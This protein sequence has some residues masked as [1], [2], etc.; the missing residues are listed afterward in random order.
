MEKT[1]FL[2]KR[3]D[4][5]DRAEFAR[6]YI[7]NHAP[8]GKKLTRTLQG[9][10]VNL[11]TSDSWID[12]VTEHYVETA[13]HLVTTTIS[14]ATPEDFQQ[15]L[16]DDRSFLHDDKPL[17]VVVSEVERVGGKPLDSPLGEKTPEAKAIWLYSDA[18]AVPPPPPGARRVLDSM[19]G[20]RLEHNGT[21][22]E[23]RPSDI[24]VI[25]SAWARDL[26]QLGDTS[27]ALVVDEYRMIPTPQWPAEVVG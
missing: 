21:E 3:K 20:Y 10:A 23:R 26:S 12:S 2:F 22:Y 11:V 8:L 14:Y 24:A 16:E 1:V 5:W 18:D 17:Y 25:R 7:G 6:H 9:Y 4:G 15:V 27:D 13:M 19:V